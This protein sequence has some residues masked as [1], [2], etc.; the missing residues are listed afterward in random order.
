MAI[1]EF[2]ESD[3]VMAAR[4]LQAEESAAETEAPAQS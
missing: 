3:D 1:L 2:V 4:S